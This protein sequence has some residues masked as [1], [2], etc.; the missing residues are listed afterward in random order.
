MDTEQRD[1]FELAGLNASEPAPMLHLA[2]G[3]GLTVE[4]A[5][6][7]GVDGVRVDDHIRV[8]YGISRERQR[9][10]LAHEIAEWHMR[11]VVDPRIEEQVNQL[12]AALI[13]PRMAFQ[14][15]V[16]ALGV[17]A[18]RELGEAFGTTSTC[19]ALRAGEAMGISLVVVSPAAIRARGL[20]GAGRVPRRSG[21]W[22][23]APISS[24]RY[25]CGWSI[26]GTVGS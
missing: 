3:L 4:P 8:R 26:S 15:M 6:H 10:A 12:A 2:A 25:G 1:L 7:I 11:H 17:T 18:W 19:M 9:F 16:N 23:D 14:R 5:R 21:G 24:L 13:A 22:C 20:S